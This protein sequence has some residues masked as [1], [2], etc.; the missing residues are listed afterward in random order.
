MRSARGLG[1]RV[2][3]FAFA[4][5]VAGGALAVAGCNT[6]AD[7]LT[8]GQRDFEA[9]EHERALAIFR[10]LEPD[11]QRLSSTDRAH[12]AYLRGMTDYRIGYKAES[13]HWLSMASAMEKQTPGALPP[14]WSKRMSEAL[15][16]LNE[17]VYAGGIASLSNTPEAPMKVDDTDQGDD[18]T[19]A[20]PRPPAP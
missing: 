8:R 5:A 7:E 15:K 20:A 17:A 16:D 10:A 2:A 6:Y 3:G 13:R 12:Y 11:V 19:P 1:Q 14:G 9:S 4:C 18:E